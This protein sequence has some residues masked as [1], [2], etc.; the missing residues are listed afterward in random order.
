MNLQVYELHAECR[1]EGRPVLRRRACGMRARYLVQF[2]SPATSPPPRFTAARSVVRWPHGPRRAR[3][4]CAKARPFALGAVCPCIQSHLPCADA[5]FSRQKRNG[6]GGL[7]RATPLPALGS[8]EID[9]RTHG[10]STVERCACIL[11][12]LHSSFTHRIS[13]RHTSDNRPEV[14]TAYRQAFTNLLDAQAPLGTVLAADL[15]LPPVSYDFCDISVTPQRHCLP[16]RELSQEFM[17]SQDTTRLSA[18]CRAWSGTSDF[19]NFSV[20]R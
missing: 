3:I 1:F 17:S 16:H 14:V 19:S 2:P 4:P 12:K 9:T 5:R 10:L 7:S 18:D 8:Q 11:P 20:I 13:H 15:F 6:R